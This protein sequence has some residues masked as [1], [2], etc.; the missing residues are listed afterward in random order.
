MDGL[1]TRE[2]PLRSIRSQRPLLLNKS[3]Q[4][5]MSGQYKLSASLIGHESDVKGVVFPNLDTIGSVS[6]DCTLR[7]WHKTQEKAWSPETL[8]T[9]EKYMNSIAYRY[10]E[11]GELEVVGGC[12]DS[13]VTCCKVPRNSSSPLFYLGHEQNVCALDAKDS[14]IVSGSW[15]LTAR[16]WS[17]NDASLKYVL[18]GHEH[19]VWCVLIISESMILTGSADKTI[20][21]WQNGKSVR[22]FTGHSDAVRA[23]C[24]L[25]AT[26]FASCSND[27]SIKIWD[28]QSGKVVKELYGH[29]S[30]IYS[31]SLLPSGELI[32]SGEDRSVRIWNLEQGQCVQ[33]I[34]FP[35]V[36]AWSVAVEKTS[37]DFAVGGSDHLIRL[38]S[39]SKDRWA[40]EDELKQFQE[41]VSGS[42][43][44]KDQVGDLKPEDLKGSEVLSQPGTKEGQVIMVRQDSGIVEAF[45]WTAGTWFKIGQVVG[46]SG[47]AQAKKTHDGK[48][49]DYVF[50]VDIEDGMPALQLPYSVT[51]NPYEAARKFIER[52]ELDSSFL[53]QVAHFIIKNTESVD[54]SSGPAESPYGSRY[55]PGQSSQAST[56][57]DLNSKVI[58]YKNYIKL[59]AFQ[60]DPLVKAL[61]D[62]NSKQPQDK[63]IL[64]SED[65]ET[66]KSCLQSSTEPASA[67]KLLG[68]VIKVTQNWQPEEILAALD[69]MRIIVSNL[70]NPPTQTIIQIIFST[71]DADLPKHALLSCRALVNL[72]STEQGRKLVSNV[73]IA[74]TALETLAELA[75]KS[76]STNLYIAI[77][78]LLVN[79]SV[80]VSN[81]DLL[82]K[83]LEAI[84]TFA[85]LCSDSESVYRLSLAFGT[86][87]YKL[88]KNG[89][90]IKEL[91]NTLGYTTWIDALKLND[92]KRVKEVVNDLSLLL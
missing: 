29:T 36:S 86:I 5:A 91:V 47:A 85:S 22:T 15:D 17:V 31:I 23:L 83:L 13:T 37:G 62:T 8:F 3:S 20:R 73:Q 11:S 67:L 88:Y 26:T 10:N 45:Q 54:L 61:A 46:S 66:I 58:P 41:S 81:T 84:N 48:E 69:V 27:Q 34:T 49:Y 75:R 64:N 14:I 12:Q 60:A 92:E 9:G 72:F 38:F 90:N 25:D 40:T 19:A 28:L 56:M 89:E 43:I 51:E 4:R 63:K 76:P 82:L 78:S 65:L 87:I 39:R 77:T 32:S 70:S 42:G 24:L 7:I 59:V 1:H 44:G 71:L 68:Y 52:H 30:Y 55:I 33:V 50:D 6:R 2:P 79:Y 21:L 80:L 53:D 18:K 57:P 74:E 35:F 16:V